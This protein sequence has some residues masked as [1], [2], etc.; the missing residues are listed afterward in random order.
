MRLKVAHMP[1]KGKYMMLR[2]LNR[3][4]KQNQQVGV[5]LGK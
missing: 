3:L 1:L 5:V 4:R 2:E